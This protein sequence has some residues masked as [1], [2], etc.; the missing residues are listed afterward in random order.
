[1]D[2]NIEDKEFL[3]K[4]IEVNEFLIKLS[5][6]RINHHKKM[7]SLLTM[8]WL[9]EEIEN[10]ENKD[11]L[12]EP[13][14][15][16]SDTLGDEISVEDFA[17]GLLLILLVREVELYFIDIL[18]HLFLKYPMKLGSTQF[19]LKE[20][21]ELSKD[22]IVIEAA[23][24]YINGL[25]YK[26]PEE[27]LSSICEISSVDYKEIQPFWSV[28]IE[29]KARRDL[30][31]HNNWVVNKIYLRKINAA[32]VETDLKNGSIAVISSDYI[33]DQCDNCNQLIDKFHTLL[34]EKH[35]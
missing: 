18:K 9:F 31:I 17:S 33:K 2:M 23:E 4:Q 25:L 26:R 34:T 8:G 19:T 7:E 12:E 30:G 22:E 13:Y 16:L 28:F 29:A 11:Y 3:L 24:R 20:A 15:A 35:T 6:V 32:G 1:M 14:A 5:K 21:I 27:Y 10:T